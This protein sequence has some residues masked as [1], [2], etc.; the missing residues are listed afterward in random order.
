MQSLEEALGVVLLSRGRDRAEATEIGL[1]VLAETKSALSAVERIHQHCAAWSGL[2]SGRLRIGSV[3]SAAVRLLP[4]R[5]RAFRT[6]YPSI[7]ITLLEGSD[8]EVRDWAVVDAVD[9]GF[10]TE[11]AAGLESRVVAED[12]FVAIVPRRLRRIATQAASLSELSHHPF[13]MSGS[14]CE[15]AIRAMYTSEKCELRVAFTVREMTTLF[16]MVR[17][18]LG[19]TIVPTL[20]LPGDMTN[21]RVL[22]L[23]PPRRR[24][25]LAVTRHQPYLSPASAAFLELLRSS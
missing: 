9:I 20:S 15:P 1:R 2:D 10:T 25:L 3:A 4:D 18:G 24:K 16:E 13:V 19:V 21:L 22:Q 12:D 8:A 14:G 7:D 5:I 23:D 17:Q 6:R 11:E